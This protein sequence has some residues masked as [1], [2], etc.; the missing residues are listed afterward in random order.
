MIDPA[1]EAGSP[2][3][4]VT[5]SIDGER[6]TAAA[7]R[8]GVGVSDHELRALEAFAIV[9]LRADEVLEA[10]RV[11]EQAHAL[12]LDQRVAFLILLVELEAVGALQVHLPPTLKKEIGI[13]KS[14]DFPSPE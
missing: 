9:D 6:R 12:I 7:G 3:H 8:L 14:R 2:T 13:V 1:D 10:R 4:A 5:K 11:D